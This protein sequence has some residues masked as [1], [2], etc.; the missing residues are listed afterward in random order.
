M[1]TPGWLTWWRDR[2]EDVPRVARGPVAPPAPPFRPV[3][4]P[5]PA[6][7]STDRRN[8][9]AA[10]IAQVLRDDPRRDALL[11]RDRP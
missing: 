2:G 5:A 10:Q 7:R 11:H 8:A 4:D 3:T 1:K 9:V 6:F